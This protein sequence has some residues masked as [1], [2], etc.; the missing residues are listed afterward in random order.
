MNSGSRCYLLRSRYSS[1][2]QSP[3]V[4]R[5][6]AAKSRTITSTSFV[7]DFDL[8]TFGEPYRRWRGLTRPFAFPELFLF[9]WH[10]LTSPCY[11]IS[12]ECGS[13]FDDEIEPRP[14][15]EEILPR[16]INQSI[17]TPITSPEPREIAPKRVA[18]KDGITEADRLLGAIVLV[19]RKEQTPAT[20][21]A[22]R[23]LIAKF[24][25]EFVQWIV[26]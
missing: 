14:L 20:K 17:P 12:M 24:S 15:E 11:Q 19:A 21:G 25:C 9:L 1:R 22:L 6:S 2:W 7:T 8:G 10:S 4:L 5:R 18:E 16:P 13:L 3:P 26:Q 23:N